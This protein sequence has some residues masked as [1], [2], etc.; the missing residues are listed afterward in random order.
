MNS[1]IKTSLSPSVEATKVLIQIQN[2]VSV[3]YNS[4]RTKEL[5]PDRALDMNELDWGQ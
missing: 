4:R 2:S 5:V 1:A 3:F